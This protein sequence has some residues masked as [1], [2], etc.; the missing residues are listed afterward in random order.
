MKLSR[1]VTDGSRSINNDV[2]NHQKS[3]FFAGRR[4]WK[5]DKVLILSPK[6]LLS[7]EF[8]GWEALQVLRRV[9]PLVPPAPSRSN[10]ARNT[11]PYISWSIL[12]ILYICPGTQL[13]NIARPKHIVRKSRR[14]LGTH[15][16]LTLL[17]PRT[18]CPAT[19]LQDITGGK[20]RRGRNRL[21]RLQNLNDGTGRTEIQN[22][23]Q[24]RNIGPEQS[25]YFSS[26]IILDAM[27]QRRSREDL[28]LSPQYS[29][30]DT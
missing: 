8:C 29:I 23:W 13:V 2:A 28:A 25:N 5:R 7:V 6:G 1:K 4:E 14:T 12:H 24:L 10:G 22:N 11:V 16:G 26:W 9:C 17:S 21:K 3:C 30:L 20:R 18:Y 27:P 15:D 19:P